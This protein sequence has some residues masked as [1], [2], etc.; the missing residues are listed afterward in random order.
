MKVFKEFRD[1]IARGNV[2][3]LAVAV[4]IGASFGRIVTSLVEGLIMPPIGMLT[5]RIDFTSLFWVLDSSK[6]VPASL[7]EAKAKGIPVL[8]YGQFLNDVINFLIVAFVIFMIVRQYNRLRS[9][10]TPA[11]SPTTKDCPYCLSAIPIKATRCAHCT[12]DLKG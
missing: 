8:A 9:P 4:V 2:V 12:S 1:F 10:E 3:D 6:G 5:G 11:A 7:A